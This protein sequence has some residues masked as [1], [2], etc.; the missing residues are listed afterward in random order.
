MQARTALST[1]AAA[2]KFI[3]TFSVSLLFGFPKFSNFGFPAIYSFYVRQ[4]PDDLSARI[5]YACKI[6]SP[7]AT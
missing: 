5:T 3:R 1:F 6:A 2:M 7:T 4:A